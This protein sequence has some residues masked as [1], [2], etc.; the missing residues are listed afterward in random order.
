MSP[1][2]NSYIFIEK[3]SRPVRGWVLRFR[4]C[5]VFFNYLLGLLA[6]SALASSEIFP[7]LISIVLFVLLAL[8]FF[9]ERKQIIPIE[10]F[11]KLA[12]AKWALPLIPLLYFVFGFP[13]LETVVSIL[14]LLVLSRFVFKTELNDY[15]YGYLI[16][17]IC[18]L[19]GAIFIQDLIFGAIFLAFY[20]C[21]GCCLM[22]YNM[23]VERVGSHSPPDTFRPVGENER[24]SVSLLLVSNA[25]VLASLVLTSL[26]FFS[27]PRLGLGL[28]SLESKSSPIS[29]FSDSVS[30]GEVGKIKLNPEVVMR[31]EYKK[32]GRPIKPETP[33]FWRG[34]ALDHYD[35]TR[36]R[37][38]VANEWRIRKKS[39]GN[40]KLFLVNPK[41][42]VVQ[43]EVFMEPIDS[44]VVFTQGI[45]MEINGS[46][47]GLIM[48]QSF[49]MR[50]TDK[51]IGPKRFFITADI[52]R[53]RFS[54]DLVSPGYQSGV[55]KKYLQVPK[56]ISPKIVRLANDLGNN[57][58]SRQ[59]KAEGVLQYLKN[60]F[61]YSL[62]MEESFGKDSLEH[63]LFTRKEGHCELF[64]SAMVVLLRLVDV[65]ARI[66]NGFVGVE[67]NE[68]GNYMI[69]RQSH[70][71]SWVE[72]FIPDRG[73][74]V[75]DPT[76]PDPGGLLEAPGSGRFSRM[77]DFMR[78][79]WQRYIVKYSVQD[80]V[81]VL[82]WFEGQGRD[83][84]QSFSKWKDLNRKE[85][86]DVLRDNLVSGLG[87]MVVIGVLVLL[88]KRGNFLGMGRAPNLPSV[89]I[90]QSML[91]KLFKY[92]LKKKPQWTPREFC[93][94]LE[95]LSREQREIVFKVTGFYEK[96]RFGACE[97]EGQETNAIKYS[98][99]KL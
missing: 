8:C 78:L 41:L 5:F 18:L 51:R 25:M 35:G 95:P 7:D 22:F 4:D 48:D 75:F 87:L 82:N 46:F 40:I 65:P 36:W 37:S 98:L 19:L 55:L 85:I 20:L 13:L 97:P 11:I 14:V 58:P 27:F 24:T 32:S 45:P 93:S 47:R 73:W 15:L 52:G 64:A 89:T 94:H 68:M 38:T 76:P 59:G 12:I 31:V 92:G 81:Q 77:M 10:P 56:D 70:A 80:Q 72:A 43:Q 1:N 99:D 6:I 62:D 17:I 86:L 74:T 84:M 49:S 79:N 67:W 39:V 21:L 42:N 69:V 66:V 71:H 53:P 9:L 88:M 83:L 29:G 63:F 61:G 54:Y 44:D 96:S 2:P 50:T 23:M 91:K 34:V 3:S 33:V 30:L 60:G 57:R 16:C 90:Y 26:I 28:F